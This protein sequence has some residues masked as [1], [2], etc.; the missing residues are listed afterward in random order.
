MGLM[1]H[2]SDVEHIIPKFFSLVET[3]FYKKIKK[4][5][6]DNVP[7]LIFV[8]FFASKGIIRQFSCVERP[9]QNSIVERKHQHVLNVAKALFFQS[10]VS[11][12]FWDEHI[13]H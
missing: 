7:K 10:H 8:D 5:K 6:Y 2:K 4:F 9:E 11:I 12:Q 13:H 3:Q 1:K